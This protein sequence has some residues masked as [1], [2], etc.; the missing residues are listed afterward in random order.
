MT[1]RAAMAV[2]V[3]TIMVRTMRDLLAFCGVMLWLLT[4]PIAGQGQSSAAPQQSVPVITSQ[5]PASAVVGRSFSF[6]L[7]ANGGSP[8]YLWHLADGHLPPGLMLHAHSGVISGVP[9]TAGEYRFTVSVA[10]S[11]APPLQAQRAMVITVIAGLTI[12]WKQYPSVQG[13][14]ISGS[15]VVNNQSGQDLD[16]TVIIVAVNSIGRA[17][18][19]GYQHL[20]LGAGQPGWWFRLVPLPVLAPTWCTPTPW[21]IIPAADTFTGF[22]NK[23]RSHCPLSSIKVG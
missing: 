13:A 14:N 23:R 9:T 22:A 7:V 11:N 3:T 19:L 4:A 16:L 1:R 2:L 5:L 21:P 8:P 12:D 20:P 15:V 6:P 10:D 17:T 18:T